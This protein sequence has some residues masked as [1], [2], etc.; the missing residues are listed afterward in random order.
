MIWCSHIFVV[1]VGEIYKSPQ[2]FIFFLAAN[3]FGEENILSGLVYLAKILFK[4][5]ENIL[6]KLH[7]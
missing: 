6:R 5:F 7:F 3:F 2:F 1:V 4:Y